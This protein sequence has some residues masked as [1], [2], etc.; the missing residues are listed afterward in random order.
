MRYPVYYFAIFQGDAR[1]WRGR[2]HVPQLFPDR[3]G[4]LRSRFVYHNG[5]DFR[6]SGKNGVDRSPVIPSVFIVLLRRFAALIPHTGL[7]LVFSM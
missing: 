2:G 4:D 3:Q 5:D 7:C 6:G 1:G